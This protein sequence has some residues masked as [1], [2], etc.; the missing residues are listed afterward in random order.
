[1][2]IENAT[3]LRTSDL[4]DLT[5]LALEVLNVPPP[6]IAV[7]F[8]RAETLE[9]APRVDGLANRE[10]SRR[11]IVFIDDE[12]EQD[13]ALSRQEVLWALQA[14]VDTLPTMNLAMARVARSPIDVASYC[15]DM[16]LPPIRFRGPERPSKRTTQRNAR[17]S[18]A[19]ARRRL[20]EIDRQI[21]LLREL[22]RPFARRIRYWQ[23]ERSGR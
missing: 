13:G 23:N 3:R 19:Y 11:L 17:R 6:K 1:M 12:N 9:D 8:A 15:A 18:L 10:S 14:M 22:R 7:A 2:K 21:K 16:E 20:A 4:R 5:Q